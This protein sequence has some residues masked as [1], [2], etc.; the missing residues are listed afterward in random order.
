MGNIDFTQLLIQMVVLIAS[1]S[2]H[3]AAHAW[4]ANRLGDPTARHLG[5]LS[6]NPAVHVDPIGTLLF[7]V[8]AMLTNL[9]I[10]GWAKPVPVDVRHLR[11]PKRDFALIAAAG[12]ASN[13][14]L[15]VVGAALLAV[16]PDTPPGDI[17]GNAL[18]DPLMALLRMFVILNVLL[19]IFNMLPV[20]PLDGGNVLIGVLPHA[21]A[22]VVEQLRP[23]G[24]I[25]LYALMLT[26]TLNFLLDDVAYFFLR[27]LLGLP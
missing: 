22:R 19:A 5:R 25:I 6:L 8:I 11:H 20:P 17:A 24:F 18:S 9:P 14:V 3:E 12:P 1:L 4:A 2:V 26:G 7:P 16:V 10:I 13:V 15:A 23:Y 27:L 21:G